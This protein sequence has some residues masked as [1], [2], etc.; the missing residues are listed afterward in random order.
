MA[1]KRGSRYSR[2]ECSIPTASHYHVRV[3]SMAKDRSSGWSGMVG[4]PDVAFARF[5][6]RRI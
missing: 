2:D 3:T 1:G 5:P 4:A 6:R